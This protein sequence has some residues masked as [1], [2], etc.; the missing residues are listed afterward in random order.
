VIERVPDSLAI[1]QAM[2][3]IERSISPVAS[4]EGRGE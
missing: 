3:L 1:Q 4:T 2:G